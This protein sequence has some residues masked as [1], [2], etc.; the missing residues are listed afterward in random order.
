[1]ILE[2]NHFMQST[3]NIKFLKRKPLELTPRRWSYIK[4]LKT[5]IKQKAKLKGEDYVVGNMSRLNSVYQE[6][7]F[8]ISIYIDKN[9]N[10]VNKHTFP[11]IKLVVVAK[12]KKGPKDLWYITRPTSEED[13]V[14]T[15]IER[16]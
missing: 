2:D 10:L 9:F 15:K 3:Q 16:K 14:S 11:N 12:R 13:Y 5:S 7:M 6:D 8:I 1:M 4:R